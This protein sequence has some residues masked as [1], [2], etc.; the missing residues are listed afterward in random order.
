[1]SDPATNICPRRLAGRCAN[2]AERDGG[3]LFHAVPAG[4]WDALCGAHPGRR[5]AGWSQYAGDGVSCPKCL[6]KLA[7]AIGDEAIKR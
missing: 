1:M 3:T 2:G 7:G 4:K 6:R 5:S